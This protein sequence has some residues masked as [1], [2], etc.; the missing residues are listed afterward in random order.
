MTGPVLPLNQ[1]IEAII[2]LHSSYHVYTHFEYSPQTTNDILS[3]GHLFLLRWS[4]VGSVLRYEDSGP[5]DERCNERC[6]FSLISLSL[7][8]VLCQLWTTNPENRKLPEQHQIPPKKQ[9]RVLWFISLELVWG[10]SSDLT[11]L[12]TTRPVLGYI[13]GRR[14]WPTSLVQGR[15]QDRH[16]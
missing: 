9:F 1:F 6:N 8:Q 7:A 3:S 15:H 12:L 16:E 13:E 10:S 4:Q 2:M 11:V 14:V 5:G